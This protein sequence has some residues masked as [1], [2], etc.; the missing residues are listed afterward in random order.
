M[1]KL[2]FLQSFCKK[3]RKPS[4]SVKPKLRIKNVDDAHSETATVGTSP[5]V[6]CQ[7]N[8]KE[9]ML[10]QH[11]IYNANYHSDCGHTEDNCVA[12]IASNQNLLTL[13]PINIKVHFGNVKTKTSVN[14]GSVFTIIHKSSANALVMDY[15]NGYWVKPST[16][17]NS[18]TF[19]NDIIKIIGVIVN[20]VKCND[21]TARDVKVTVVEDKHRP[22]IGC[23]Q[24]Q[25][26]IESPIAFG[27]PDLISRIAK[28]YKHTV[29]SAFHK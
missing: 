16:L 3:Y 19:S 27:F 22:I 15:K 4:N 2:W 8:Q 14:S 13:K 1:Q 20:I 18:K 29:K 17:R 9:N 10:K 11:N 24:N 28:T 6:D 21:W 25:Y 26:P 12:L 7:V 23:K 5:S